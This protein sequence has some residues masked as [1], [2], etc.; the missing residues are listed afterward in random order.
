M[1][2]KPGA[3]H[4]AE[5]RK[6]FDFGAVIHH[7]R[8]ALGL[9][10][11]ELGQSIGVGKNAVGAWENG[12][13]RP[14][15]SSVPELCRILS[16]SYASFFGQDAGFRSSEE[17]NLLIRFK[18]L[19]PSHRQ[20]ILKEI[21]I[22]WDMQK[23]EQTI[24]RNRSFRKI[25]LNDVSAAAG[26]CGALEE[27]SGEMI[28]ISDESATREADEI[29]RVNG[30]SMSPVYE[31]GDMVFVKH[32]RNLRFGE[33]GIFIVGNAGY[34]KEYHTDGLFSYNPSYPM[35]R[36]EDDDQVECIGKV[37]GKVSH[38]YFPSDQELLNLESWK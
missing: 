10:Q 28:W 18:R 11:E 31:D 19:D 34:I 32:T 36:F 24:H 14:D 1:G 17:E 3:A 16:I 13:S 25:Y 35:M 15:L 30:N 22:L 37:I 23:R 5:S 38:E 8:T 7:R 33:V 12:R 9:S 21:D 6:E 26:F 20:Y 27:T 4:G 2:R 29:I